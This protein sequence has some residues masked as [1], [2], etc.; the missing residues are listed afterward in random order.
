MPTINVKA[1]VALRYKNIRIY[2]IYKN[3][4]MGAGDIRMY[5]FG[6]NPYASDDCDE[7][8]FDVRELPNY[9]ECPQGKDEYKHNGAI[10]RGAIDA[11]II[12]KDG[13]EVKIKGRT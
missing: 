5:W 12:Y 13:D 6:L 10:I 7:D 4:D 11:G 9:T 8:S 3:D 2:H 1:A